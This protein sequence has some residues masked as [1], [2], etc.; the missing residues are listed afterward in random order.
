M[1]DRDYDGQTVRSRSGQPIRLKIPATLGTKLPFSEWLPRV[2]VCARA[3]KWKGMM[4][5]SS[6]QL[7]EWDEAQGWLCQ[8]VSDADFHLVSDAEC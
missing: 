4:N 7:E 1:G 3:Y 5:D 8:V 2:N 6:A